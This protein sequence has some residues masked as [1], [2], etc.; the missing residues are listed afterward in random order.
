MTRAE[1]PTAP[2]P[3]PDD[4]LVADSRERAVRALLRHPQLRRLW[5][6]QLVSGVGDTLALLVLVVLSLQAAFL[7][8]SF[9]GGYRGLAFAVAIVFAVRILATLLFGAVLLGP[10][11]AL[12]SQDGPLDRRWT[13][14]GADGLRAA[15]LIV[16]PLWIDWTPDSAVAV[17]LVTVFLTA[18]AERFWTV[19]RESAAPALLPAPPPEGA[20]VRPLPDHIG[21]LRRLTLRTGFVA[22]PLAAAALV[23]AGLLNNLL[24]TGIDWFDQHQAAL[25]SYV[26][27]GL[28]AASLSV[29]TFLELPGTRTPRARSP[30]EGCAARRPPPASTGAAPARSRCWCSP[31]PPWQARSPRP[32]AWPCCTPWTSAAARC[33]T[34]CWCSPS[35]AGSSSVSA[36]R[37]RSS[38]R[39]P[40]AACW[41]SRPPS[42]ASPCSPPASSPTSPACC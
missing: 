38:P 31:A 5:S 27:A 23:A 30:L 18:V 11:T 37:P 29:L 39:C 13:M 33:C 4:A 6:A 36:R 10:L 25:G 19:C 9:G 42:P 8:G 26:A 3:A 24:G 22:V 40:A 34:A 21:T 12:T 20:S 16:A 17:L 7:Q 14:V 41:P 1:Q 2:H 15:L 28:F 35:P 32:S